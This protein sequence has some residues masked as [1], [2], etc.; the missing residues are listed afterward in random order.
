[1]FY[2]L[3]IEMKNYCDRYLII[4][5]F[6]HH[7]RDGAISSVFCPLLICC[8]SVYMLCKYENNT[9]IPFLSMVVLAPF[10]WKTLKSWP[11]E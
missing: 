3:A 2:T 6:Q 7:I 1:M 10:P 9:S 5:S 11:Q 4:N 8:V